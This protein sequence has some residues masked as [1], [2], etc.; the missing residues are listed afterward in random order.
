MPLPHKYTIISRLNAPFHFFGTILSDYRRFWASNRPKSDNENEKESK[1][2]NLNEFRFSLNTCIAWETIITSVFCVSMLKCVTAQTSKLNHWITES[3]TTKHFLFPR[4][5]P[6]QSSENMVM[7]RF[8][9][10]AI[11]KK[12]TID[13]HWSLIIHLNES[14]S[15]DSILSFI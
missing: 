15:I 14:N 2:M 3:L 10:W 13:H 11:E 6:Q 12:L 5:L 8:N 1:F 9:C 4:N 7:T